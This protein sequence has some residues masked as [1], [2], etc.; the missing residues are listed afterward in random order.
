MKYVFD[1]EANGL[2]PTADKIWCIVA[3]DIVTEEV[4]TFSDYSSQPGVRSLREGL[5]LL[6]EAEKL[7]GHNIILYDS[8]VLNKLYPTYAIKNVEFID[9]LILSQLSHFSRPLRYSWGKHDLASFGKHFG[10]HKPEQDQWDKF[11]EAMIHRCKEDVEINF[12]VYKFLQREAR[13]N[14]LSKDIIIRELKTALISRNQVANGWR[15]D[16]PKANKHLDKLDTILEQL[17]SE[18]EPELPTTIKK[19]GNSLTWEDVNIKLGGPFKRVPP[20]TKDILGDIVKPA[21]EPTLL[22]FTKARDYHSHIAK[23]FNIPAK[24]GRTKDRLVVGPYTKVSFENSRMSQHA[25]VKKFLFKHGWKPTTWNYKKTKDDKFVKDSVGRKI[26]TTPKLTEDS[27]DSIEGLLGKKIGKFNTYTSRRKVIKNPDKDDKGWLNNLQDGRIVCSPRTIGAATARMTHGGLVNVPSSKAVFGKEMRELFIASEGHQI[28][29][30]DMSSA[31]LRLLAAAIGNKAYTNA[32]VSGSEHD[33]NG[34]YIG[35]DIHSVNGIAAGLINPNWERGSGIWKNGEEIGNKKWTDGRSKAKTFIYALLFGAG[36]TKIGTIVG[37]GLHEGRKLKDAFLAKLPALDLL[38]SE[39]KNEWELNKKAGEGWFTGLDGRRI[40]CNS[41]HKILNFKLQS[42]E[43]ILL[44]QWL[45][46]VEDEILG[47]SDLS[48]V[49]LLLSYHDELNY[50]TIPQEADKLGEVLKRGI[51]DA[52]KQ[53]G[54]NIMDGNY[55]IGSN[56]AEVH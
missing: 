28:V 45:I 31:Q 51:Q 34:Y 10:R 39:L 43:A 9:T 22:K 27:F 1:V 5:Y 13:D 55:K 36:E 54:I 35:T 53:F 16:I 12:L 2:L 18:I 23:W 46:N 30:C 49:K 40:Y 8:M 50:E 25:Q 42:D 33:E 15:L 17:R 7:I 14:K 20:V 41:P 4:Y 47:R 26:R 44:K 48:N 3:K 6:Q 32:V 52:G 11:E 19:L 24:S 38:M 37:G 21:K 56:W 29:A